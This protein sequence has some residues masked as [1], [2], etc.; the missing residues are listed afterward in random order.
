MYHICPIRCQ[1]Q[2]NQ[3]KGSGVREN[4]GRRELFRVV[5]YRHRPYVPEPRVPNFYYPMTTAYVKAYVLARFGAQSPLMSSK[6]A[7]AV[8]GH[9]I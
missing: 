6:P 2:Q 9:Y 7:K 5:D 1:S 4:G 3:Q 8:F